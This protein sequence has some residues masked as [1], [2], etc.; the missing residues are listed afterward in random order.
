MCLALCRAEQSKQRPLLGDR[1]PIESLRSEY[2]DSSPVFVAKV[3]HLVANYA[4]IRRTRQDGNCFYRCFIFG[5]LEALL[6]RGDPATN[7]LV[8]KSVKDLEGTLESAGITKLVWEDAMEILLELLNA[9][10][11]P[12]VFSCT[13]SLKLLDSAA[14]ACYL[15][16]MWTVGIQLLRSNCVYQ[17]IMQVLGTCA[18]LSYQTSYISW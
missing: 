6:I 17:H 3:A 5:L 11:N 10:S 2:A 16:N 4:G 12:Q 14:T 13:S 7:A 8:I 9:V 15:R 18:N 1:G